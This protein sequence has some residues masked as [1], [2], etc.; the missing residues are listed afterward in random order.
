MSFASKPHQGSHQITTVVRLHRR[1]VDDDDG[2]LAVDNPSIQRMA[3]AASH[4]N[5][6]LRQERRHRTELKTGVKTVSRHRVAK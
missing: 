3:Y 4:Q 5:F 6:G 2:C 1:L